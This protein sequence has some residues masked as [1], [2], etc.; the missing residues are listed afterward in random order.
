MPYRKAKGAVLVVLVTHRRLGKRYIE[1]T[2]EKSV[3]KNYTEQ[4]NPSSAKHAP[5]CR[6][7]GHN[8]SSEAEHRTA[9][10]YYWR[11]SLFLNWLI[12]FV[13]FGAASFAYKTF[14]Q[15]KRQANVAQWALAETDRPA[16]YVSVENDLVDLPNDPR[17]HFTI[18]N[19]AEHVGIVDYIE[20]RVGQ[21]DRIY[22]G[23]KEPCFL[24]IGE[25]V[26]DKNNP[27]IGN[28]S[29]TI[30]AAHAHSEYFYGLVTY[31]S[32][33]GVRWRRRFGYF[34]LAADKLWGLSGRLYDNTDMRVDAY[35]DDVK[36]PN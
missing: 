36:P 5:A 24:R 32:P 34:Y 31:H 15:T 28:C 17:V 30:S 8:H 29:L 33:S 27:I 19:I 14:V 26:I 21:E 10:Q 12:F 6:Y 16:I 3:P 9:E 23:E 11:W 25:Y 22:D 13:A 1:S 35:G 20:M 4:D 2:E 7:K 18:K